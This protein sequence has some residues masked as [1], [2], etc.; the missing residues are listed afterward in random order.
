VCR[1]V[2]SNISELISDICLF[3]PQATHSWR[4]C[5][6]QSH[7]LAGT[8]GVAGDNLELIDKQFEQRTN[9]QVN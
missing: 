7:T 8:F 2:K 5:L 6:A 9:D 4:L 1:L 3:K